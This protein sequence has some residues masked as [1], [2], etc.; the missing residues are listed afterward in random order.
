MHY[1]R[2]RGE[3]F[4]HNHPEGFGMLMTA[5]KNLAAIGGYDEAWV[6]YGGEDDDIR[7]RLTRHGIKRI[8][9]PQIRLSHYDEFDG[10]TRTKDHY[11]GGDHEPI[12]KNGE[13][14]GKDFQ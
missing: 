9:S 10:V 11:R 3:P 14:W 5:T 8:I 1:G 12:V 4:R 6:K 13:N 2:K 7:N